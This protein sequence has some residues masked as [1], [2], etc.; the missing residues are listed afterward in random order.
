MKDLYTIE[1]AA[2]IPE[3][4]LYG[5]ILEPFEMDEYAV[6]NLVRNGYTIFK[7]NPYNAFEKVQVT[8]ENHNSIVFDTTMYNNAKTNYMNETSTI[9]TYNK[10]EKNN[11]KN[12][13]NEKNNSSDIV[14]TDDF[15]K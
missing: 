12:K 6:L 15:K 7:H 2:F 8:V 4:G 1:T 10:N 13:N 14:G 5:P 11:N 9:N 3:V